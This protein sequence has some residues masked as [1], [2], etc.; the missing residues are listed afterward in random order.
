MGTN[1]FNYKAAEKSS[2]E[3]QEAPNLIK[4][5]ELIGKILSESWRTKIFLTVYKTWLQNPEKGL[6]GY[7]LARLTGKPISTV[8]KFLHEMVKH[9]VFEFINDVNDVKK[10]KINKKY[11]PQLY[12][13]IEKIVPKSYYFLI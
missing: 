7:K 6:S 3:K 10:V 5:V 4:E 13:K 9:E 1:A 12:D 2:Y 8:Y 11:G